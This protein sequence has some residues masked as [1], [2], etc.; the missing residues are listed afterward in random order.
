M[1]RADVWMRHYRNHPSVIMWI[2][3][4]NFFNNAVDADPRHIGRRGWDEGDPRWQRLMVAGQQMFDG[5]KKLDP[6]RLYY[7]HAGAYT[8]DI[9]T[10]NCYLDLIPLQ[11]RED[12]LSAWAEKGE[13]PISMV[14]F[15][16][17]MD[18][19]FR[20]GRE[21]FTSNITSEP[22]LTEYA[23]IYFGNDAYSAE[24][25]KYRQF[26]HDLFR[27]GMLYGSSE[28]RLDE[29]ADNHKLQNLL[30]TN[31]WRSWRAA[32][33]PGGL[34][35][36]S[37]IQDALRD[38]NEP[39]LAWIAGA[40]GAYTSK[41]HHFNSG[42]TVAKQIVLINDTRKPQEFT[43]A[44]TATVGGKEVGSGKMRGNLA[45][46]EIRML[47][48][49]FTAPAVDGG[50]KV[51]G[52]IAMAATIGQTQQK[53]TFSF[54]VFGQQKSAAGEIAVIDSDGTAGRMLENLGYTTRTWNGQATPLVVIGRNGFKNNPSIGAKL[55]PFVQAGGRALIC[56]QDPA[57]MTQALALRI[58]PQV[59]RRVFPVS[60]SLSAAIDADDLRDW[61]GSSTLIEA[62]PQYVGDYLRGN[63][64]EQPYAGWHWGNRG[65][66]SSAAIEKPHRSG[67][68]PLLECEFDLAYSPLMELD[69]GKG[70]VILCTLDLEDHVANDPAARRMAGALFDYAAH[71]PVAARADKVQYIGEPDGAAWLQRIGV[72]FERSEALDSQASLVLIGS[73]AAIG[74][75]MFNSYLEKGG[76]AF[77]LPRSQEHGPLS[78]TLKPA[79]VQFSGSLTAPDWS[80]A[81]GLS[82]SDLRW[83][84]YLNTPLWI[85]G[86]GAEIGADGLLGR[87]VIGKGVAIFCQIDPDGFH[88]DEQTYFRYTRWR[89]TRAVAQILANLGASF[90]VDGRIFHPLDTWK[91]NLD[92]QWQMRIT[93]QLP[94]AANEATAHADPGVSAAARAL[95]AE[96]APVDGWSAVTLP[97]M[98][99][100][101]KDNDG[102]AVFRKEIVIPENETGKDLILSLGPLNDF[103]NTFFNGVEVG[104]TGIT[105]ANFSQSARDYLVPARLVKPGKN[106]IAVRLF[107]RFGP[108]GFA[109]KP[110]FSMGPDGNRSGRQSSGPRIGLEMSLTPKPQGV[111]SLSWY[112]PD[113]RADF[114]MG[115]NPY[116][117]YRW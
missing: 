45:V 55:E 4:M 78:T 35:T 62:F 96:S 97:Q 2:A 32:G 112:H 93:L 3:G 102:E 75:A 49:Q 51:D 48:F 65:A 18:C 56:A 39:T 76:K 116:R 57:W 71:A 24:E 25:P 43:A 20:R 19:T 100:F 6:T 40:E 17:P 14:E 67:W 47:P 12:W 108:G 89:A 44:W 111:Q 101:F 9:Y 104:N 7:S 109:G 58:C 83:R 22:L 98:L 36:W 113:Y 38:V 92:G 10:M 87:K 99:P 5:L 41:D 34:R 63:E 117:Y 72:N 21:G 73:D 110:G 26:V 81:C 114:Q 28:N 66:V 15:G 59:S 74:P 103:D 105:T 91:I 16:T 53:D 69:Y 95:L 85:V 115:D 60:S 27:S 50:A 8:G 1:E 11:E 30:R 64:R 52:Q 106:L 23:A 13:M 46:S 88:A 77:F 29:Y 82:A 31:T 94:Q 61:N 79:P 70:R 37:W 107:N 90:A 84:S 33:L 68:R 80:E 86:D 54:R 42:Q